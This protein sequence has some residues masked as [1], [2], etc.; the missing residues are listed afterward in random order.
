MEL[1]YKPEFQIIANG[2]D[3]TTAIASAFSELNLVDVSGDKADTLTI[4]L[5]GNKI[6]TLPP[7]KAAL[8]VSL[9]FNNSLYSQGT[10][11]V[12]SISDSGF[13]EVVT[14]TATSI[15]Q[16][17]KDDTHIQTQKTQSWDDITLSDLI[18]TLA[19][20]NNLT[21]IVNE[22][23]GAIVIEHIDQTSE[24]DMALANRLARQYGAVSKVASA[25]WLFLKVGEGKNASG[26]ETLPVYTIYK[27]TCSSYNYN[28]NSKTETSSAIAKW[29]NPETGESGVEQ[30]GTGEPAFQIIYPFPTQEEAQKAAQAKA[31][32]LTSG[33]ETF[34][35]TPNATH[36]LVK[37]FAEGYIQPQG[38]RT[39][40]SD[41]TW[42]IKQITKKL[43]PSSG[44]GISISCDSGN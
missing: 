12:N 1:T 8:K 27:S 10:F 32:T 11:Y 40:I 14:I 15:P 24:S 3:I 29:N 39:E 19:A 30:S 23:L 35:V 16:N 13:P 33:S 20:R 44:L 7:K 34:T 5:D 4:K 31:K 42:C 37:A 43:T 41:Q 38:W 9:G 28:S 25:N 36:T 17:G 21:P 26:T 6:S 22:E 2:D 18:K